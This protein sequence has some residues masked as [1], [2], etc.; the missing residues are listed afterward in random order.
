MHISK[1]RSKDNQ[2][3]DKTIWYVRMHAYVATADCK[4]DSDLPFVL[5]GTR[6]SF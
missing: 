1:L 5:L 6:V 4:F 3:Q 2:K